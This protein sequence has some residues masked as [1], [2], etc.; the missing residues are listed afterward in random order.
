MTDNKL[1]LCQP[2]NNAINTHPADAVMDRDEFCEPC[3]SKIAER[4]L[5]FRQVSKRVRPVPVMDTPTTPERQPKPPPVKRQ[6]TNPIIDLTQVDEEQDDFIEALEPG[7]HDH[8][9]RTIMHWHPE[10]TMQYLDMNEAGLTNDEIFLG[11]QI[12]PTIQ[13][14]VGKELTSAKAMKQIINAFKEAKADKD[15]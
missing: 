2:C 12:L 7:K 3:L 11:Q 8:Q 4:P 1:E 5:E 6:K 15:L 13:Q 10:A 9:L 14:Y